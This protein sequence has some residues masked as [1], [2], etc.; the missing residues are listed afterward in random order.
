MNDVMGAVVELI[1]V[2]VCQELPDVDVEHRL[3]D[4]A[5]SV[6]DVDLVLHRARKL[7][8]LEAKGHFLAANKKYFAVNQPGGQLQ[9][10]Q[11]GYDEA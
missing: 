2:R 10:V 11:V 6:D 9:V 8:R 1:G 3:L 5:G 7:L 4:L